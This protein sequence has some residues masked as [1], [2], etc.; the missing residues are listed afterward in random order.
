[1]TTRELREYF[2][3]SFDLNGWPKTYEVDPETYGNVCR[4]VLES[5]FKLIKGEFP[6]DQDIYILQITVGPHGGIFFKGVELI[7]K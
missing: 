4:E 1:M 5:K 2:N 3:D 7:C 6:D